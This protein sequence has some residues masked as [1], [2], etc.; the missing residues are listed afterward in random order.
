MN[1]RGFMKRLLGAIVAPAFVQAASLWL[2][3]ELR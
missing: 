2:P 3:K 1:R